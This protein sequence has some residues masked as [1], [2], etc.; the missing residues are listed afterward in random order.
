MRKIL[1]AISVVPFLCSCGSLQ[2]P[3]TDAVLGAGGGYLGG[4]FS[5]GNPA[6]I[7]AGAGGAVLL[8]EGWQAWKSSGQLKAY[9]NGYT[10]GRSDGVK[11]LYWNLQQQQRAQ[12]E[13]APVG[14][15]EVTIPARVED[16]ILLQPATRILRITQ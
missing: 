4:Q 1:I 11:Q 14:L 7:A 15:Y 6:A 16:G 13:P 8:G 3:L 5:D 12:P 2:R 9:T 10:Q